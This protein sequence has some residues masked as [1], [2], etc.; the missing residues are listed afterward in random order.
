[1]SMSNIQTFERKP[2]CARHK[3]AVLPAGGPGS[4]HGTLLVHVEERNGRLEI[5][6]RILA[7]P[8]HVGQAG[9]EAALFASTQTF[10]CTQTIFLGGV[11]LD[12]SP[13]L[14]HEVGDALQGFVQA[15]STTG[16]QLR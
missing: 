14:L 10:P 15:A 11:M 7:I 4:P 8:I 3:A 12:L 9:L 2:R 1:M 13:D 5:G 6:E 16:G